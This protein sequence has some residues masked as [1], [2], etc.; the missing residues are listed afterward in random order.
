MVTY[1]TSL[2]SEE[3][4]T[5]KEVNLSGVV[6]RA[7]SFHLG[8]QCENAN[9]EFMLCRSETNDPRKCLEEGKMVTKCSLEFFR[10][11]KE[12][13]YDEFIRHY[14]CIDR[15]SSRY[16]FE[17][18]RKSQQVYDQCVKDNM[19]MERPSY[20]YFCLPKVHSTK[21]PK[22]TTETQVFEATPKLPEDAPK[23]PPKYDGIQFCL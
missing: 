13:C 22:P 9:N 19:H 2:P 15:S 21:R 12:T 16:R 5:V 17:P 23:P 8:K 18:C 3:E 14:K 20:G 4:L 1:D 6:L 10:Q 11:L 7:A